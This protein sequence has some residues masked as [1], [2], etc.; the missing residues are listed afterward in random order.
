MTK[1]S[2]EKIEGWVF[3]VSRS[4]NLGFRTIVAPD[5]MCDAR[6]SSLIESV[7]GGK[8]TEA[9][10]AI[11]RQIH[12]SAVGNL[13]LVFRVVETTYEDI[14]IEGN[15]KIKDSFGRE[16]KF[17][18]GI[19]FR[20]TLTEIKVS[21]DIFAKI[22]NDIKQPYQTFWQWRNPQATISSKL[23]SFE[24]PSE[25]EYFELII[26]EPYT[27]SPKIDD[28]SQ[29]KWDLLHKINLD[30]EIYDFDISTQGTFL[31]V[32]FDDTWQTL[33]IV[34][35]DVTNGEDIKYNNKFK[36]EKKHQIFPS[37]LINNIPVVGGKILEFGQQVIPDIYNQS[38]IS[39]SQ[40]D[41]IA[42]GIVETNSNYI[43]IYDHN[44]KEIYSILIES[45]NHNR[46]TSLSFINKDLIICGCKDGSIKLFNWKTQEEN[47]NKKHWSGNQITSIAISSDNKTF[48]S[49]DSGGNIY[50][51]EIVDL[52]ICEKR[53]ILNAHKIKNGFK[54]NSLAFNPDGK[55]L[56]SVGEDDYKIK[57]WNLLDEE[58]SIL[59]EEN[60]S[61]LGNDIIN[62]ITFSS[63]GNLLAS[64][65]DKGYIKIWDFT[66]KKLLPFDEIK[67]H[68][69]AVTSLA[70]IPNEKIL[71][72]GSKDKTIKFWKQ[73]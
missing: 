29:K 6:V 64:G 32:R 48:A 37:K 68:D 10:K 49:S 67:Q 58:G 39:I 42:T 38:P 52:T 7:A 4:K 71:I 2:M 70:F 63:D 31:A 27:N 33:A 26:Q 43:K 18:E 23:Q 11:Y 47:D 59:K 15:G 41:Y 60:S 72:S 9:K 17:I 36:L 12:N 1:Y 53:E 13:T 73:R 54:I 46:I 8:T 25:S 34:P 24:K 28:I 19:V 35:F 5:F 69:S 40:N 62:T 61:D 65:D 55:I 45:S 3:L 22:H 57:L 14:E 21:E 50:F 66:N 20:G 51:W 56:A 30:H 16:I 44:C